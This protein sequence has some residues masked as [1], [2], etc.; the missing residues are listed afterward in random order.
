[1]DAFES[2]GEDGAPMGGGDMP[3]PMELHE[4]MGEGEGLAILDRYDRLYFR[5]EAAV[6]RLAKFQDVCTQMELLL[7][8][9]YTRWMRN[10]RAPTDV[11]PTV[12]GDMKLWEEDA[13]FTDVVPGGDRVKAC[14]TFL[15]EIDDIHNDIWT[16]LRPSL[17][18]IISEPLLL[19][20][21]RER[22]QDVLNLAEDVVGVMNAV[23]CIMQAHAD[24]LARTTPTPPLYADPTVTAYG[25][26]VCQP[27]APFSAAN[28][29]DERVKLATFMLSKLSRRGLRKRRGVD[30]LYE[31]VIVGGQRTYTYEPIKM[32]VEELVY[33]TFTREATG[34]MWTSTLRSQVVNDLVKFVGK[35]V[36]TDIPDLSAVN[37][38]FTFRDGMYDIRTDTFAPWE[39]VQETFGD[40]LEKGTAYRFFPD[41][42]MG[43]AYY[44]SIDDDDIDED[45]R[46]SW[47]QDHEFLA[48]F[49][50][51]EPDVNDRDRKPLRDLDL[52][53]LVKIF[54][55]QD[56][57]NVTIFLLLASLG[58]LLFRAGELDQAQYWAVLLGVGGSGKSTVLDIIK[59]VVHA[60][61]VGTISADSEERFGRDRIVTSRF[62]MIPDLRGE[63]MG[64]SSE[65][66]LTAVARDAVVIP[67]KY[68]NPISMPSFDIQGI[69]ATNQFPN[70]WLNDPKGAMARRMLIFPFMRAISPRDPNLK[71]RIIDGHFAFFLRAIAVAYRM[72]PKDM[73]IASDYPLTKEMTD[74]KSSMLRSTN[75]LID[76]LLTLGDFGHGNSVAIR[77]LEAKWRE[78]VRNT[79]PHDKTQWTSEYYEHALRTQGCNVDE[80]AEGLVCAFGVALNE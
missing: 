78:Y 67:V 47:P 70:S 43:P 18:A 5:C 58:R 11:L 28:C 79:R 39:M 23:R 12:L 68:G 29:K 26:Y 6:P 30:T 46:W 56:F 80:N 64:L 3:E 41:H 19:D 8:P 25:S 1:M 62:I 55:D 42:E 2:D 36:D 65:F 38:L 35:C 4:D 77:D 40:L 48:L 74:A 31:E 75:T 34:A 51:I 57:T 27:V 10:V 71:R 15:E 7:A 24:I 20:D 21:L 9:A 59:E 60:I 73:D 53:P 52:G 63:R 66:F 16:K 54:R 49:D 37:S 32:N 76:M 69:I 44:T 22:A 17:V 13:G 61:D 14:T 45:R 72:L 50:D 33:S